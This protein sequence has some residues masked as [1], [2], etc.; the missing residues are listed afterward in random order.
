MQLSVILRKRRFI[1][2]IFPPRCH[3]SLDYQFH[4]VQVGAAQPPLP[5]GCGR[6][7]E[8][9]TDWAGG[10]LTTC[11]NHTTLHIRKTQAFSTQGD[12]EVY[13]KTGTGKSW[14]THLMCRTWGAECPC[15]LEVN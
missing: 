7:P 4:P 13:R 3:V 1:V 15:P 10:R 14:A 2:Q 6:E 8:R 5:V 11:K 12:C 9:P